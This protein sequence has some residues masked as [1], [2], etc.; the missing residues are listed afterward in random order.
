MSV[1]KLQVDGIKW[2]IERCH[3]EFV[4]ALAGKGLYAPHFD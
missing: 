4:E 3:A 1:K 2:I